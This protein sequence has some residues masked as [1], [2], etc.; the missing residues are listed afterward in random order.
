MAARTIVPPFAIDLRATLGVLRHGAG[1]PTVRVVRGEVW[2][3]TRTPMGPAT[4]H[5]RTADDRVEAEAWGE[6]AEWALDHVPDLIGC[7]DDRAGFAPAHPIVRDLHRR[8]PGLRIGRTLAVMESLVPA[9]IEQKVT[10]FEAKR[11]YRQLVRLFGEPAPGPAGMHL[12]PA[13]DVL[14]G[15]G[16]YDFH[17]LGIERKRADTIRRACAH[18]ARLHD[19]VDLPLDEA[20]ERLA[21]LPGVGAWTVAEVAVRALGDADAVSVGDYHLKDHVAFVL[22]GAPRGTDE[23]MLELLEPFAG[24]RGRVCRLI[25]QSGMTPPRWGPRLVPQ[26]IA[27]R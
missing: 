25:E 17:P 3:A 15:L 8:S 9:I 27:G 19:L 26:P 6:G 22:T 23:Q 18:A 12:A 20:R 5:L 13:P 11:A 7:H 16:Y 24:H 10:G 21:G 4:V 1:D 2:R 14:S